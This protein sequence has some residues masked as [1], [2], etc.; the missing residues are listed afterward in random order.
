MNRASSRLVLAVS[1]ILQLAL[2]PHN[3]FA[4]DIM[5]GQ[6]RAGISAIF[7]Q[8]SSLRTFL[9]QPHHLVKPLGAIPQRQ[10]GKLQSTPTALVATT[11]YLYYDFCDASA[12][13]TLCATPVT[14]MTS[15]DHQILMTSANQVRT[16]PPEPSLDNALYIDA[17]DSQDTAGEIRF[18]ANGNIASF[19]LVEFRIQPIS[20]GLCPDSSVTAYKRS[21]GSVTLNFQFGGGN[22]ISIPTNLADAHLLT[23][24]QI[25]SF[26]INTGTCG[27]AVG[28]ILVGDVLTIANPL[29]PNSP[30]YN[31]HLSNP[32]VRQS[33][34]DNALIGTLS[35]QD[36]DPGDAHT[37]SFLAGGTDNSLFSLNGNSLFARDAASLQDGDYSIRIRTDDGYGGQYDK[38]FTISAI[39]DIAPVI[40]SVSVPAPGYYRENQPLDFTIT[41]SETLK[42]FTSEGIP[43]LQLQIGNIIRQA[44]FISVTDNELLFRYNVMAGELDTDGISL[45][46]LQT[47]GAYIR[48]I[49]GN[50][51]VR[52]LHNVGNLT[53]VLIDAALP[54]PPGLPDL[55]SQTD[56]GISDNDNIT[57]DT[58]PTLQGQAESNSQVMVNSSLDGT[59]GSVTANPTGSWSLTPSLPLSEGTHEIT[60]T[61][62]DPAGNISATSQSL[63]VI[64]DTSGPAVSVPD[65]PD[66]YDTGTSQS[67]NLTQHLRPVLQGSA[68]SG[69]AITLNSD[70]DGVVGNALSDGSGLWSISPISDLSTGT[71]HINATATDTAGNQTNSQSL[72][73]LIDNSAPAVSP[74]DLSSASD[75]GISNTD[76]ITNVLRPILTG[77]AENGAL[78]TI[79]SNLDGV[80][81]TVLA[82]GSGQWQLNVAQDLSEGSH[83][84]SAVATDSAGNNNEDSLSLEIIIDRQAPPVPTMPD[85]DPG[86]DSGINNADN[87]TKQPQPLL[88]GHAEIGSVVT[89]Y[90]DLDG[91]IGI[92]STNASGQWSLIPA[93]NLSEGAHNIVVSASDIAGNNSAN[94]ISL[95]LLLDITAPTINGVSFDP[96][97]IDSGN[98]NAV[99]ITLDDAETE[100]LA[101]YQIVS[102]T[103]TAQISGSVQVISANQQISGLDLSAL[104]DGTLTLSLTLSD[105]A[106][107]TASV[108]SDDISKDAQSP[109]ISSISVA[110][111]HYR[112]GSSLDIH[113]E[114]NEDVDVSGSLSTLAI[115]IGS[116]N[117]AANFVAEDNGNI[118][119]RYIVQAMDQDEDGITL[120]ANGIHLNG[121]TLI[122]ASG[123]PASLIYAMLQLV[124][125]I[126][127]S[128]APVAPTNISLNAPQITRQTD[129]NI[130]GYHAE[131]G[132]WIRFYVDADMDGQADNQQA[133]ASVQ[134]TQN[135]WNTQLPLALNSVNHWLVL[136]EDSAGNQSAVLALPGVTQDSIAP[137]APVIT[138]PLAAS[139]VTAGSISFQG[140][141]SENLVTVNLYSDADNNGVADSQQAD[142]SAT[143]SNQ[144]WTLNVPLYDGANNFV[145]AATDAAGN[146]SSYVDTV[147]ITRITLPP[148]NNKPFIFGTPG[149]QAQVGTA[150]YFQPGAYDPDGDPLTFRIDSKPAWASFNEASGSLSGTPTEQD[151]GEYS[152]IRISVSDGFTESTLPSFSI[153]VQALA[154][155]PTGQDIALELNED[156]GLEILP[157]I[158][159]DHDKELT[160]VLVSTPL[161]G[162]LNQMGLG[163]HYQPSTDYFGLDTFSYQVSDG[164]QQSP[165]HFV[166]L[167][168]NPVNDPPL[169]RPDNLQAPFS[170][171]NRYILNVLNNDLDVDNDPL[172]I[173]NAAISVGSISVVDQSLLQ[174][175]APLGFIGDASFDYLI[176]DPE[177]ALSRT[178]G[179]V[180][181]QKGTHQG[182]EFAPISD[183]NANAVGLF[184]RVTLPQ[185]KAFDTQG[186]ELPVSLLESSGPYS[187]GIHQLL[188]QA[189]SPQGLTTTISQ[190]LNVHPLIA[191]EQDRVVKE[192]DEVTLHFTLNGPSPVYP[193][194]IAYEVGGSAD[195]KDHNL[196]SGILRFI[197]GTRAAL[198]FQLFDDAQD[199][200]EETLIVSLV[201]DQNVG[202]PSSTT[203]RIQETPPQVTARIEVFQQDQKRRQLSITDGLV[204]AYARLSKPAN[205]NIE[206]LAPQLSNISNAEL[207]FVFNPEQ[208]SPGIY[209]LG[210]RLV[211]NTVTPPMTTQI[212]VP[213]QLFATLPIL[214]EGDAD[215]DLLPDNIDGHS[216]EDNDG[217]PDYQDNLPACNVMPSILGLRDQFLLEAS[218]GSC[219]MKNTFS[220]QSSSGGLLVDNILID[221]DPGWVNVG[222]WFDFTL[223]ALANAGQSHQIVIPLLLPVPENAHYRKW[224]QDKWQDFA[225]DSRNTIFSAKGEP[226]FCPPPGSPHYQ[227]GLKAGYHCLQ[228]RLQD[229]GPNDSDGLV[230]GNVSD[231]GGIAIIKTAN[232]AP[233]AIDDHVELKINT[234]KNIQVLD[235]DFDPDGDTLLISDVLAQDGQ[236]EIMGDVLRYS[237]PTNYIGATRIHYFISDQKGGVA[238]AWVNI[239]IIAN[240]PPL[241]MDDEVRTD[242]QSKI[243]IA[244]LNN[245]HDPDGDTLNIVSASAANGHAEVTQDNMISYQAKASFVG[246]DIIFYSIKD[247]SGAEAQAIVSVTVV[248]ITDEKPSKGAVI[249]YLLAILSAALWFKDE[250]PRD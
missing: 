225:E 202:F 24:V 248:E 182:P 200:G 167:Q 119:Y 38:V 201:A 250:K 141:H 210:L 157:T 93:Q 5:S 189:V 106:G 9:T 126:I 221:E 41:A 159:G 30:P 162:T 49:A 67:D 99:S 92:I 179:R 63:T 218:P 129:F 154:I 37:Y 45:I 25:S 87:I 217:I 242:N 13:P 231:P 44:A 62:T 105:I 144:Q 81:G 228:L 149:T 215:G 155:P 206:W 33:Q 247:E 134:V 147:T 12:T 65:V 79:S 94:S 208:L 187:P 212:S 64:I 173:I 172:S 28:K 222:G 76:N 243:L 40:T 163:W 85:L 117:R 164:E 121:D 71:H 194:D 19:E 72:Q 128:Q 135:Q 74:P 78:V 3:L 204:S 31:I 47:G 100:T 142:A 171:E 118:L 181:V 192:G 57:N 165:I 97:Q 6:D 29:P 246:K 23:G 4:S 102:S 120:I 17:F 237:P 241:A 198:S 16:T 88:K 69:A 185:P 161:H 238:E 169:A 199:E 197:S 59:I 125:V 132:S 190:I 51:L 186:K 166:R 158:Q 39:D 191:L 73:L 213:L 131:N 1:L 14:Q 60:A 91:Q 196:Q 139:S 205:L 42:V 96:A 46:D 239:Q 233:V 177:G 68:E 18:Y 152:N 48:D 133:I 113:V 183:I 27:S 226:G 249:F 10:P 26:T 151:I 80:I 82:D 55:S 150:Y 145:M 220:M 101:S 240:Q 227:P 123:N 122:D 83:Q 107:N 180:E 138:S 188:W 223:Y 146:Q 22:A 209:P 8:A 112:P 195:S 160:L 216:D 184:T 109:A 77:S 86:S 50:H 34:G 148:S 103:G 236:A 21:G 114:L 137:A 176:S 70:I 245:D 203:L 84:V 53:G 140:T 98:V 232:Q 115:V 175:Q 178:S 7:R 170:T 143:V 214:G 193:L 130:S 244:A 234:T 229:G 127:D 32:Y 124:D 66:A 35:T 54:A 108:V 168:I 90:S 230:N 43:Y 104:N 58:T 136:A 211:D 52:T 15:S 224:Y 95:A 207:E 61:A 89:V 20:S 2:N 174:W 56:T 116:E 156:H 110:P 219:L 75:S 153:E 235:N 36:P 11:S 111:G